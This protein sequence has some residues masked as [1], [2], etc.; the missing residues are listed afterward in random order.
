MYR[1]SFVKF[2]RKGCLNLTNI[3]DWSNLVLL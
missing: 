2:R 3:F 1:F